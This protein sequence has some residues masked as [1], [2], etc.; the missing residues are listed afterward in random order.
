MTEIVRKNVRKTMGLNL[1][2][3][4]LETKIYPW[5]V[6]V[7]N[8]KEILTNKERMGDTDVWKCWLLQEY[9]FIRNKLR[10]ELKNTE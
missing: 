3:I 7:S 4:Y 8:I 2:N 9:I 1:I 10:R 5:S 6:S